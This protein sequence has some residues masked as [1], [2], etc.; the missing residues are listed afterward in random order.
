MGIQEQKEEFNVILENLKRRVTEAKRIDEIIEGMNRIAR[1][2]STFHFLEEY[3]RLSTET[4][5][6]EFVE[7]FDKI[8]DEKERAALLDEE[9]VKYRK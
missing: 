2:I 6:G 3:N 9:L 4:V 5:L 1:H 7:K 8:E